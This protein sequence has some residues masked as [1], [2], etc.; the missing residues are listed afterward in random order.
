MKPRLKA[1]GLGLAAFALAAAFASASAPAT[2]G[3]H[4]TTGAQHTSWH[5]TVDTMNVFTFA[6]QEVGCSIAKFEG[7]TSATTTAS[8]GLLPIY[9]KCE[10][11]LNGEY[12]GEV[13]VTTNGCGFEFTIGQKAKADN[14][15]HLVCPVGTKMEFH[16]VNET[17]AI[18]PQTFSG[19][20]FTPT[21][22]F[23]ASAL[24]LDFTATGMT[25]HCEGGIY[26]AFAGTKWI[27]GLDG[28]LTVRGASTAEAPVG[29]QATGTEG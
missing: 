18:P 8:F 29:I 5:G 11:G 6:G 26:C 10:F 16:L 24:T 1:A 22:T 12:E 21:V 17:F 27:G 7:T 13:G 9:E 25:M 3:G 23:G 2:T 4:F 15:A 19:V 20:S 28:S 14:T